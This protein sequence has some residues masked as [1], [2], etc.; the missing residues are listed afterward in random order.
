MEKEPNQNEGTHGILNERIIRF[1]DL[2]EADVKRLDEK[3]RDYDIKYQIQFSAAKEALGIA[4]IA[5][6]KGTAA[7]LDG[8]SKAIDKA[9]IATDK[10]FSL[11]SEKIDGVVEAI[12]KN[13]GQQGIYVTHG[14]LSTEMEKLRNSFESMLQPVVTFMNNQT[15]QQKGISGSWTTLISTVGLVSALIAIFFAISK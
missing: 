8:T 3:F 5:Q 6:E 4:L 2:R 12:S 14:D 11:L 9:D 15:G 1:N 7:A 13:S 10:R